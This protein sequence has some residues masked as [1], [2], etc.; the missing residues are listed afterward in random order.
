MT[1]TMFCGC[2]QHRRHQSRM[3]TVFVIYCLS[4]REKFTVPLFKKS[5]WCVKQHVN[6]WQL[7][8]TIQVYLQWNFLLENSSYLHHPWLLSR[9]MVSKYTRKKSI[10]EQICAPQAVSK[11]RTYSSYLSLSC[12]MNIVSTTHL[13]PHI[14]HTIWG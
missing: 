6:N 8:N 7:V 9:Y 14:S 5:C 1:A 2:S 4:Q 12:S 11:L 3:K 10:I 13:M